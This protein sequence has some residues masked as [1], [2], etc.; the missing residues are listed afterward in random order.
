MFDIF[1]KKS[2]VIVDCFSYNHLAY[3][4]APISESKNFVPSWF[5]KIP[6]FI[7]LDD[8][9][10]GT[11]KFPTL[12]GCPGVRDNFLSGF[13]LPLWSE[14]II[15]TSKDNVSYTFAD[16]HSSA[17]FHPMEQFGQEFS[18]FNLSHIKLSAPW[19]IRANKDVKF[20]VTFPMWNYF[21]DS[22]FLSNVF[23]PSGVLDFS[24]QFGHNPNVNILLNRKDNRFNLEP[25]SPLTQFI[26]MFEDK[27]TIKNHL[28]DD[29]EWLNKR[30]S[31]R[32]YFVFDYYRFKNLI[33]K[34]KKCP[35]K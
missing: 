17:D 2:E 15:K 12:K 22:N 8:R 21:N 30:K 29:R 26:P 16:N 32:S 14:L 28:V 24:D 25:G 18:K 19:V 1:V 4:S 31:Q 5:K 3:N 10:V 35:F 6:N 23:I 20:Y 33:T 27:I 7:E 13:I 9:F 34:N 11:N